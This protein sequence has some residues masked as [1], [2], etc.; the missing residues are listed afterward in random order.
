MQQLKTEF[1]TVFTEPTFPIARPDHLQHKIELQDPTAPPPKRRLYP[2][3]DVEL[4]E[5]KE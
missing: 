4:T 5:L 2:L 1:S 3:S